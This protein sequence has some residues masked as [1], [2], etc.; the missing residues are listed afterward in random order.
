MQTKSVLG[1]NLLQ[2][3]NS[4]GT[5]GALSFCNIQAIPLTDSMAVLLDASVKRVSDKNRNPNNKANASELEYIRQSKVALAKGMEI[6]P[7]LITTANGYT[8]YYPILTNK[9]CMQCHGEK[10]SD[11]S[12]EVSNKIKALYPAD[13]ATGYGV[14]QL[15]GI[16]VV[17]MKK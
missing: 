3:I 9:M 2:A 17:E 13:L 6:E 7:K 4:K 1:K 15:R 10:G 16:W 5:A 12:T 11:I 14:D 8:G